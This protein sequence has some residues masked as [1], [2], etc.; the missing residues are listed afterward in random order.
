MDFC[1]FLGLVWQEN[2]SQETNLQDCIDRL[3]LKSDIVVRDSGPKK[4]C[5]KCN[6]I[7]NF[8]RFLA[9]LGSTILLKLTKIIKLVSFFMIFIYICYIPIFNL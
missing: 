3:S 1:A 7:K 8:L 9:H 4:Q 5:S 6:K 2:I